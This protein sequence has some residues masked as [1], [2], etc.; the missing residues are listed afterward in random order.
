MGWA[1]ADV[2]CGKL[3][4]KDAIMMERGTYGREIFFEFGPDAAS[5][6][7]KIMFIL[8]NID[9]ASKKVV[10]ELRKENVQF[11]ITRNEGPSEIY[12]AQDRVFLGVEETL[13]VHMLFSSSL[14][15]WYVPTDGMTFKVLLTG[16]HTDFLPASC[17]PLLDRFL[18]GMSKKSS[19][20]H[21][22]LRAERVDK[23][24]P[25]TYK[26]MAA[27]RLV[28]PG[29]R[30]ADAAQVYQTLKESVK[31]SAKL[32]SSKAFVEAKAKELGVSYQKASVLLNNEILSFYRHLQK[33]RPYFSSHD[34]NRII[35]QY[36]VLIAENRVGQKNSIVSWTNESGD[37]YTKVQL[38]FMGNDMD[39]SAAKSVS[40]LIFTKTLNGLSFGASLLGDDGESDDDDSS[41]N[42]DQEY[43]P[44]VAVMG[45]GITYTPTEKEIMRLNGTPDDDFSV[46]DFIGSLGQD[47]RHTKEWDVNDLNDIEVIKWDNLYILQKLVD[48]NRV[49][50]DQ[51]I[52]RDCLAQPKKPRDK[53]PS[54]TKWLYSVYMS[55]FKRNFVTEEAR[56]DIAK[57]LE[58]YPAMLVERKKEIME[59]ITKSFGL[60]RVPEGFGCFVNMTKKAAMVFCDFER[61]VIGEYDKK[62][63]KTRVHLESCFWKTIEVALPD[64]RVRFD[65]ESEQKEVPNDEFKTIRKEVQCEHYWKVVGKKLKKQNIISRLKFDESRAKIAGV[66]VEEYRAN[67]RAKQQQVKLFVNKRTPDS[68]G[69]PVGK[70]TRK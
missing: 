40:H 67:K 69:A 55:I 15:T 62:T 17:T 13:E 21:S 6:I 19:D 4:K 59:D 24:V 51:S 33:F 23:T 41:W 39:K 8:L 7:S 10:L 50:M 66:S 61:A 60:F 37:K 48:Y 34:Y 12:V 28:V 45:R 1:T 47:G 14:K 30:S 58:P 65:E 32:M 56:L 5:G 42:E 43:R 2:S 20:S 26:N 44:S 16:L 64:F 49:R 11:M 9:F 22:V 53:F 54:E 68:E 3:Q 36:R 57:E 70:R 27:R 31:G 46:E 29:K 63:G 52:L 38:S 35:N 18:L 25:I